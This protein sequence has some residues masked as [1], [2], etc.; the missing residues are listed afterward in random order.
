M[1]IF[2]ALLAPGSAGATLL[3]RGSAGAT[4]LAHKSAGG[5]PLSLGPAAGAPPVPAGGAVISSVTTGRQTTMIV[6]AGHLI[7]GQPASAQ[8]PAGLPVADPAWEVVE[9][10]LDEI[11]LAYLRHRPQDLPQGPSRWARGAAPVEAR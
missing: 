11:V 7:A 10:T 1:A 9:P 2:A 6:R 8:P 4:L 3:A 5:A